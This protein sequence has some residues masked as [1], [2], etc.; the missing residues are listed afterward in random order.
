[1]STLSS[2]KMNWQVVSELPMKKEIL[3]IGS[4]AHRDRIAL[5][6]M[7][8][9]NHSALSL[10]LWHLCYVEYLGRYILQL[11]PV[12]HPRMGAPWH[13]ASDICQ[14]TCN[15]VHSISESTLEKK[16]RTCSDMKE[17]LVRT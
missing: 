4:K 9:P 8:S 5:G 11:V 14:A 1:M 3:L 15:E 2:V 10:D 17:Y 13:K 16:D 12:H 6:S 7:Q